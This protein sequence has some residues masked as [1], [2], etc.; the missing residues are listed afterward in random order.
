MHVNVCRSSHTNYWNNQQLLLIQ[1]F[2]RLD[3]AISWNLGNAYEVNS[4]AYKLYVFIN[5]EKLT[6]KKYRLRFKCIKEK[7]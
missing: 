6:N 4:L 7:N 2:V 1:F 3:I 5:K